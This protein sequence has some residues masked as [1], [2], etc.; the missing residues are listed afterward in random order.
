LVQ[1]EKKW[2]ASSWGAP[3]LHA[4]LDKNEPFIDHG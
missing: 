4:G 3:Q 1:T 2:F